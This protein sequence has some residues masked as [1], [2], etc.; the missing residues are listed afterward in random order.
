MAAAGLL[1]RMKCAPG[2]KSLRPP[3]AVSVLELRQSTDVTHN[4]CSK[5]LP[6]I[7]T[8]TLRALH[9]INGEHYAG[10]ERV[11]DLL[12]ARLPDY[13]IQPAFACLKPGRFA[14]MRQTQKRRC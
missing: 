4:G 12:A 6:P 2:I 9:V 14:A 13:G 1:R 5:V 8:S 10:A 7:A 11:Q 3:M